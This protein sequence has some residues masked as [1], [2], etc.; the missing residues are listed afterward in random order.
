M[1]RFTALVIIASL[2]ACSSN[3]S[4][5]RITSDTAA[6]KVQ[7]KPRLEPVFYNGKTY[8][9]GFGPAD[10]GGYAVAISGMGPSQQKDALGLTTSAFHHFVCKD[11][12]KA[13]LLSQPAFINGKWNSTIQCG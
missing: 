3:P 5:V 1:N 2:T 7:A 12:Q 6:E 11:S 4:T 10:T 8:Q 13:N 9:V